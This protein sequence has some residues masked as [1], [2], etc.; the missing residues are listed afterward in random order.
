[1]GQE[2]LAGLLS[3][4]GQDPARRARLRCRTAVEAAELAGEL[5]EP[6][7]SGDLLRDESRAFAW[8]LSDGE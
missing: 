7:W 8:Q 2:G 6:V 5:G 1:M 4:V 3:R